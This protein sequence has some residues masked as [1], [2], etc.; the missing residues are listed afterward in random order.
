MSS[1]IVIYELSL[2]IWLK[3]LPS[4]LLFLSKTS[5]LGVRFDTHTSMR[6]LVDAVCKKCNFHLRRI[7]SIRPYVTK[8]VCHS[9]VIALVVSS[10]DYCNALMLEVPEYHLSHLQK[11]HN[12]AARLWLFLRLFLHISLQFWWI[13]IGCLSDIKFKI[14]VYIR[15]GFDSASTIP[16]PVPT[17]ADRFDSDSNSSCLSSIPTLIPTPVQLLIPI[18]TPAQLLI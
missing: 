5:N 17:P 15:P 4:S 11:I 18:L 10:L 9:L 16:T 12:R 1:R 8:H 14:L 13:C 2:I 7:T 6:H 3:V